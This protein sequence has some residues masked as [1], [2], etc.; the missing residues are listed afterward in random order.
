MGYVQLQVEINGS[1]EKIDTEYYQSDYL[2][3]RVGDEIRI[4]VVAGSQSNRDKIVEVISAAGAAVAGTDLN[5]TGAFIDRVR[6]GALATSTVVGV[7]PQNLP[8]MDG[9]WGICVGGDDLTTIPGS[10]RPIDIELQ[11]LSRRGEYSDIPD[12]KNNLEVSV[13]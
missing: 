8:E 1:V 5:G 4:Q 7:R 2:E 9:V 3:P 12:L 10:N 11:V 6:P 13:P